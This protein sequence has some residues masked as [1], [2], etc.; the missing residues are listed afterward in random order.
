MFQ[1]QTQLKF[2]VKCCKLH[3]VFKILSKSHT[4]DVY[5]FQLCT[6]NFHTNYDLIL[7]KSL[8]SLNLYIN[9]ANMCYPNYQNKKFNRDNRDK[10]VQILTTN[11]T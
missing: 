4:L 11:N 1:T 10:N 3:S 6:T 5:L 7:S 9:L 2:L 8:N